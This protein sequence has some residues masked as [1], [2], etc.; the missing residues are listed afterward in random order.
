MM[1]LLGAALIVAAL[2]LAHIALTFDLPRSR[3]SRD[4]GA[5]I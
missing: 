2:I 1:V 5:Q 4:D 3:S